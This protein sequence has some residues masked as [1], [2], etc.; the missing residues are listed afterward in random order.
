MQAPS[1]RVNCSSS[2][3]C[4]VIEFNCKYVSPHPPDVAGTVMW[5]GKFCSSC[6]RLQRRPTPTQRRSRPT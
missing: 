3:S 6:A 2:K 4:A 1:F 5:L